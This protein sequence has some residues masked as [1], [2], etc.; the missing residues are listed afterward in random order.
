MPIRKELRKFYKTES[1]FT[2]RALVKARAGDKCERCGLTNGSWVVREHGRNVVVTEK[3][4]AAAKLRGLKVV[5][6]QC[7]A[8]HR[9]PVPP[10][11]HSDGNLLWLCRGC[12]RRFDMPGF[13]VSRQTRKDR[14]RPLLVGS[15]NGSGLNLANTGASAQTRR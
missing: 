8:A 3:D 9:I 6:I 4:A 1:W 10:P 12:H 13:R 2:A 15:T 7:G 5:K 11:D 14:A